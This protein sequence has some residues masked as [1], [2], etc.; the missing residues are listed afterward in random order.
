MCEMLT[1]VDNSSMCQ[2][3]FAEEAGE[4]PVQPGYQAE[5]SGV[6]ALVMIK[7]KQE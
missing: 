5:L 4:V 3:V 1:A 6:F 7:G 2:M